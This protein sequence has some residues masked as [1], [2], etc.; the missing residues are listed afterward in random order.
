GGRGDSGPGVAGTLRCRHRA[1]AG[2]RPGAARGRAVARRSLAARPG[3][4]TL[5]TLIS[6]GGLIRSLSRKCFLEPPDHGR[7]DRRGRRPYELA[8]FLE[9]VHDG[10][11]L[12]TEL[13]REF[14][15]P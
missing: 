12:D 10:L 8:H 14:V 15:N 4:G 7:L 6:L 11:A 3:P 2:P 9:L 1:S 13:F 5:R